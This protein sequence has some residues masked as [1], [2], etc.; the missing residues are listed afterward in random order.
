MRLQG[1]CFVTLGRGQSQE[2]GP[3]IPDTANALP[4]NRRHFGVASGGSLDL[5][6]DRGRYDLL[7]V[8]L[9][10]T[11]HPMLAVSQR[12]RRNSRIIR[13]HLAAQWRRL[14][15]MTSPPAPRPIQNIQLKVQ[16]APG[17]LPL[18]EAVNWF[19]F[20]STGIDFQLLV[21]YIDPLRVSERVAAGTV[22]TP[23]APEVTHRF[24]ISTN[25]IQQLRQALDEIARNVGLP[26]TPQ[27]N[28]GR[29]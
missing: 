9:L 10:G 24:S 15:T 13:Q 22:S 29:A 8:S 18:C 20:S 3:T 28:A 7:Q 4:S 27:I 23:F 21:G 14:P 5:I 2:E 17:P 26:A 12:P 6:Y 19:S 11:L 16:V 1:F 25:G